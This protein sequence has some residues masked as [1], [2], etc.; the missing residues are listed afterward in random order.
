MAG[1][2]KN[3]LKSA[4]GVFAG[5]AGGISQGVG[6]IA[7]TLIDRLIKKRQAG[8]LTARGGGLAAD[9]RMPSD[10]VERGR[11]GRR[12]GGGSRRRSRRS[13]SQDQGGDTLG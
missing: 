1:A 12:S 2:V 6:G 3:I 5:D 7:N 10:I 11:G 4:K 13:S 9:R 8:R